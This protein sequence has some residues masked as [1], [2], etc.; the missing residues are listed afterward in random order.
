MKYSKTT[1]VLEN[2]K[3]Y[4]E[5]TENKRMTKTSKTT[6]KTAKKPVAKPAKRVV[7]KSPK[8]SKI[9]EVKK[10][11]NSLGDKINNTY[12]GLK[13]TKKKT[14]KPTKAEQKISRDKK[15]RGIIGIGLLFVVVSIAYS[16]YMTNLFVD[17][18]IMVVSLAP[19]VIFAGATLLIAFYKIYK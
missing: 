4:Y 8:S 2:F 14:K 11:F 12:S 17:G 6:A 16:T 3:L 15:I 13:K 10:Y 19:Q 5:D 9:D 18:P 1:S 7:N